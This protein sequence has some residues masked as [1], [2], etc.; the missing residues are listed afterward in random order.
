MGV[1]IILPSPA[2]ENAKQ[3]PHRT[4]DVGQE[5]GT[6]HHSSSESGWLSGSD[7]EKENQQDLVFSWIWSWGCAGGSKYDVL[8][9]A[10]S[11]AGGVSRG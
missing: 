11:C 7:K 2:L 8:Q 6:V 4:Q 5:Q 3:R 10:K 1:A 9:L